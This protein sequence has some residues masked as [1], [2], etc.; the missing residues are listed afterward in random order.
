MTTIH[1][2]TADQ[3]LQDMPHRDLR[4][5]RA[6]AI[7]LIPASTGAAKA[8]G[9]VL[10]EL[11]GKLTGF[12][13]RAP[14][15]TGSVVDL[16]VDVSARDVGGGDQRG[17]QGQGRHRR[18]RGHP[19]L[20]RR[21]DRLVGHR[22]V[23]ALVDLRLAADRWCSTARWSRSSP[24]TTTSGATPTAVSSSRSV[25]WCMRTL[26][27]LDVEGKRVLVRVDFNVPL[28]RPDQNITDDAR[29]RGA[30]PT[31][32]ELR[33]KGAAQLILLAHLGRP[34]DRE[35]EVLAQ[36]RRGAPGRAARHR[37]RARG[38]LRRRSGVRRGDDGERPLR[39]GGDE[40]RPR[41]GQ[42]LRRARGRLRQRRVRRR[43]PRARLDGGGRAPAAVRRGPPA[44]ARGQDAHRDPRR[45]RSARSWRSSAAPR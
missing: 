21:P 2:Y 5:A 31:L 42:A 16:T 41:A 8:V 25:C 11:K 1:A 7:N 30:L 33:E 17:V 14:V 23:D 13:V 38:R 24:G 44:R 12:A 34:K 3:N 10:P 27:D 28:G 18:P 40:E 39:A 6:A 35:P 29:I 9:L 4:R 15:P 32:E 22:Q 26:D 45:T 20:H 43:P 19:A 37:G 36:A